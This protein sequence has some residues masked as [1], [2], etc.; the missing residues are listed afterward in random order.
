MGR[1]SV[2]IL[3]QHG[4]IIFIASAKSVEKDAG[5]FTAIN[6]DGKNIEKKDM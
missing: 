1:N 3:I 4:F 6:A 2:V 5:M